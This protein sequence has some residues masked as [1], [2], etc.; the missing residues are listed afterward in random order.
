MVSAS[1]WQFF[2]LHR[3]KKR[4]IYILPNRY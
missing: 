3:T 1:K 4:K 2:F